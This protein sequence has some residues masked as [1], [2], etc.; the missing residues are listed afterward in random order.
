MLMHHDRDIW[1]DDVSEF[2][3]E[4]FSKGVSKVTKGQ[5]SYLPFGGGPRIFVGLNFALLEAKMAL[6]MIPQHFCFDLSPSYLHAPHTIATL[7]PQFGAH[8]IL[9]K[10]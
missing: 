4:R 7:Q 2:K 6:V 8:L 1:S 5:T 10:L 9:R 3:P